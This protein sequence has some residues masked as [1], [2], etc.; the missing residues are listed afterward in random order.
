M[1]QR[2]SWRRPLRRQRRLQRRRRRRRRRRLS[3]A[4]FR[5]SASGWPLVCEFSISLARSLDDGHCS[6]SS[7]SS[8]ESPPSSLAAVLRPQRQERTRHQSAGGRRLAERK[9]LLSSA[10]SWFAN[11]RGSY[12]VA[13]RQDRSQLG[14]GQRKHAL[15]HKLL[16]IAQQQIKPALARSSR[17]LGSFNSAWLALLLQR[18]PA[19]RKPAAEAGAVANMDASASC[20]PEVSRN[21]CGAQNSSPATFIQRR[22]SAQVER[23][24]S[25]FN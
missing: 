18:L 14:S 19:E 3:R 5:A 11:A 22:D 12:L 10:S 17:P 1:I 9:H 20:A 7:S 2:R 15:G 21:L 16:T 13:R 25:V 24:E 6:S 23:D 8:S 4:S